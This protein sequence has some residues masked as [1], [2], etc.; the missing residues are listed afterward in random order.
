ML[1]CELRNG[2]GKLQ[3]QNVCLTASLWESGQIGC[4]FVLT[5]EISYAICSNSQWIVLQFGEMVM[6]WRI[7]IIHLTVLWGV[8]GLI[9]YS[10]WIILF[11]YDI[12]G[13]RE[14]LLPVPPNTAN[15]QVIR[16]QEFTKHLPPSY[17]TKGLLCACSMY[18]WARSCIRTSASNLH[19]SSQ[20]CIVS[21]FKFQQN[22]CTCTPLHSP[23]FL[24]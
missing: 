6:L 24:E 14:S 5:L 1:T 3:S 13:W 20:P 17:I 23:T 22:A 18:V 7:E 8:T 15:Y 9:R 12:L 11:I 4:L 10:D 19:I 21:T 2:Y 16:F